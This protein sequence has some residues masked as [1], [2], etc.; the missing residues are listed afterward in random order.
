MV[1]LTQVVSQLLVARLTQ[2]SILQLQM[3]LCRRILDSP[4]KHLEEIGSPRMLASLTGDVEHVFQAMSGVPALGVN[5]V[6]LV[7]G[8]V[9]LGSLSLGLLAAP[10]SFAA[11]SAWPAIGTPRS[12]PSIYVD[13][14]REEQN[15]LAAAHSRS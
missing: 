12:G 8:A 9:Y 4:V 11:F 10:R 3:G 7:C 6:I 13:R 15:V 14:A 1:L 5:F 2:T